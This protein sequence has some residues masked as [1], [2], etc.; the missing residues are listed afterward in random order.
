MYISWLFK[1]Y[2]G[3][4]CVPQI[5]AWSQKI[6]IWALVRNL[7]EN[8]LGWEATTMTEC[9]GVKDLDFLSFFVLMVQEDTLEWTTLKIREKIKLFITGNLV[10]W[11]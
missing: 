2:T 4:Y 3:V 9:D 8:Q 6:K 1:A 11:L 5:F 10:I 7:C